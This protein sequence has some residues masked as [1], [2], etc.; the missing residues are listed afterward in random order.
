MVAVRVVRPADLSS[1]EVEAWRDLAREAVEP[2]PFLEPEYVLPVVRHLPGGDRVM[3]VVAEDGGRF[4]GVMAVGRRGRVGPL[5]RPTLST[6]ASAVTDHVGFMPPLVTADRAVETIVAMLRFLHSQR[7]TM[8]GI[9]N[10]VHLPGSG[11]F[12]AALVA[13]LDEAQ[14]PWHEADVR[15]DCVVLRRSG[16]VDRVQELSADRR[17]SVRRRRRALERELGAELRLV[18]RGGSP[19]AI[20]DF[21]RLEALGWKGDRARHG[22]AYALFD[23]GVP[24]IRDVVQDFG[25]QGRAPLLALMAGETTVYMQILL[26][27]GSTLVCVRDAYDERFAAHGPGVLGR[28]ATI[29]FFDTCTDAALLTTQIDPTQYPG[30]AD[31]YPDRRRMASVTVAT[32]GPLDRAGVR[33]LNRRGFGAALTLAAV[34]GGRYW[35]RRAAGLPLRWV[36][37]L[38]AR[39]AGQGG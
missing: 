36:G 10:L 27:S 22:N 28:L 26:R 34:R 30:V 12:E 8:P 20:E 38:R 1:G 6:A 2:N 18:D 25:S 11:P 37:A 24:W 16:A 9:L 19:G 5:L 35:L 31:L 29:G 17:K 23:G 21:I 33:A 4:T 39:V 15:K 3:L 7:P 14:M 32:G 13:A